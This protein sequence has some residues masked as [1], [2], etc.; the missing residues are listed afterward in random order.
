M[1]L[2]VLVDG[3]LASNHTA[4]HR[5]SDPHYAQW[6]K[7]QLGARPV[8]SINHADIGPALSQLEASSLKSTTTAFY[9][10]DSWGEPANHSKCL[11]SP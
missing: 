1:L 9:L 6:W 11:E 2:H 3:Y 8:E 7:A 4:G 5:T 10:R